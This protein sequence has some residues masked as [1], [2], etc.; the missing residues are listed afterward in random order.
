MDVVGESGD[1]GD[2]GG[3]EW[4]FDFLKKWP[5]ETLPIIHGCRQL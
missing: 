4:I 3:W 2:D 5:W 1:D